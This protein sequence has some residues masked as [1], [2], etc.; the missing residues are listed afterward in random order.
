ME[1]DDYHLPG[2]LQAQETLC[3]SMAKT[4]NSR[5]LQRCRPKCLTWHI[6]IEVLFKLS[7]NH[8]DVSSNVIAHQL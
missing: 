3:L 4:E 1:Q 6:A 7:L 2:V 5:C 8:K